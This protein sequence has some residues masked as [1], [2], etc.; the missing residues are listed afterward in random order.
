GGAFARRHIA[1]QANIVVADSL[2]SGRRYLSSA[3]FKR[4]SGFGTA[5][6]TVSLHP[7]RAILRTRTQECRRFSVR[8]APWGPGA[9]HS[10]RCRSCY[11]YRRRS[12]RLPRRIG[13]KRAPSTDRLLG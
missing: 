2:L 7:G 3:A 4:R 10:P 11:Q 8:K 1:C 6:P 5:R 12:T 13:G 9:L